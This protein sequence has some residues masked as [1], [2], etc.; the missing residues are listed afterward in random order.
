MIVHQ[1]AGGRRV[2]A[3]LRM[4]VLMGDLARESQEQRW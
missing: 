3:D 4:V 1:I 2:P